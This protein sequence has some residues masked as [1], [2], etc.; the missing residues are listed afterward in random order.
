MGH[1]VFRQLAALRLLPACLDRVVDVS[2]LFAEGGALVPLHAVFARLCGQC[3]GRCE[4][5]QADG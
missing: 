5:A 3:K 1:Q 4:A 2:Y